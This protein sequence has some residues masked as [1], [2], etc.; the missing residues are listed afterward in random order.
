MCV[1]GG[2]KGGKLQR[3]L[4]AA[5]GLGVRGSELRE[6]RLVV[7]KPPHHVQRSL[8]LVCGHEVARV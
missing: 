7:D 6:E 3:F 2:G 1:R 4:G 5:R 8:W